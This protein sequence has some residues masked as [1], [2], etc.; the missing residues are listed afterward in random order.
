M[1][2]ISDPISP[3]FVVQYRA[4]G[5]RNLVDLTH[6]ASRLTLTHTGTRK[7]N[8]LEVELDN[9]D[10]LLFGNP[11]LM[12]KGT[13]MTATFGYP[14]NTVN[15]G[16][17]AIKG[18][19]PSRLTLNITAHEA[20]RSQM[21]RRTSSRTFENVRRSDVVLVILKE[22]GFD[23]FFGDPTAEILPSVVKMRHETDWQFLARLAQLEHREFYLS[24]NG[25]HWEVPN[26]K[27]RPK[28]V[29]KYVKNNLSAGHVKDWSIE[30][31]EAGLPGRIIVKG[32]DPLSGKVFTATAGETTTD[33]V[34]L[35]EPDNVTPDDGDQTAKGTIGRDIALNIGAVTPRDAQ[36]RADS[37]YKQLRYGALKMDVTC[38]G[39]PF[40][41]ARQTM[42]LEGIGPSIDG[43]FW[44]KEV[45]HTLGAGYECRL[46]LDRDGL[47]SKKKKSKTKPVAV[48]D[49]SKW[50]RGLGGR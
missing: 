3:Y 34:A 48:Q 4:R 11:D 19:K 8:K 5:K 47:K 28:H 22:H 9:A 14:G 24:A 32:F 23:G 27:Q 40:Y 30:S 16:Q 36:L 46:K 39:N 1:R 10:Q 31:L 20:K 33:I 44:A 17:F 15:A 13:I 38:I 45:V 37:L 42:V 21:L 29:L 7:T 6:R 18:H 49:H 26:R 41:R 50:A 2:P 35:G 12:R 43:V 25:A